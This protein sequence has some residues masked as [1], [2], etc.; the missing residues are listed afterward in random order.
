MVRESPIFRFLHVFAVC[1]AQRTGMQLCYCTGHVHE[2]I[3]LG[4][5]RAGARSKTAAED[6]PGHA[7]SAVRGWA[8]HGRR[9]PSRRIVES[10]SIEAPG[11]RPELSNETREN[12]GQ[13]SPRLEV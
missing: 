3:F 7:S 4:S 10:S 5:C 12:G 13:G 8:D 6:A 9:L 1:S 2:G 11:L